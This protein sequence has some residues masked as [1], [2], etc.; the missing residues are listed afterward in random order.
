[1]TR[2]K[3]TGYAV[4]VTVFM[5]IRLFCERDM[6]M[7]KTGEIDSVIALFESKGLQ[8]D[9]PY[10]GGGLSKESRESWQ[11]KQF[12]THGAVN[13]QF[14]IFLAGYSAGKATAQD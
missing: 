3:L 1:M 8:R 14:L 9:L 10:T 6:T 13:A 2:K 11:K 12:Y 7:F 5:T 4:I